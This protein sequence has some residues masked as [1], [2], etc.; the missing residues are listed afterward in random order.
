MEEVVS[1]AKND[2]FNKR[3]K[4]YRD[5]HMAMQKSLNSARRA[6]SQSHT[7]SAWYASESNQIIPLFIWDTKH[8]EKTKITGYDLVVGS[9]LELTKSD[10]RNF[11]T[12]ECE[13]SELIYDQGDIVLTAGSKGQRI[14]FQ[15]FDLIIFN[16]GTHY[17]YELKKKRYN[18]P[19]ELDKNFKAKLKKRI[20]DWYKEERVEIHREDIGELL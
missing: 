14:R 2:K 11:S 3:L 12:V 9:E 15:C 10:I 20:P 8:D 7:A 1:S 16:K 13:E 19:F 5:Q 4:T 18:F 17:L 6:S